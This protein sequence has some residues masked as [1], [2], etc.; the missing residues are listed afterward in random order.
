LF[1]PH[2][3]QIEG[4]ER[5]QPN[6]S[7][8]GVNY[9]QEP[10]TYRWGRNIELLPSPIQQHILRLLPDGYVDGNFPL[11][12]IGDGLEL[13]EKGVNGLQIEWGGY[14]LDD[15]VRVGCHFRI[16]L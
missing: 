14:R 1:I 16:T 12:V 9:P 11:D 6:F 10:T 13:L 2:L 8:A 7:W 15:L 5:H 3:Q 4:L